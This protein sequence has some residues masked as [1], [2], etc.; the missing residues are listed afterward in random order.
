MRKSA[1]KA[2]A[3]AIITNVPAIIETAPVTET[4][5][6][7]ETVTSDEIAGATVLDN[8]TG[9]TVQPEA[10]NDETATGETSNDESAPVAEPDQRVMRAERIAADRAA[11]RSLY[12]VFEANRLSVPVKP[13]SAFKLA[14]STCH[15]VS[16]N[17]SER[18]AAA[19]AVGLTAAGQPLADGSS[20]ARVFDLDGKS[21]ALENGVLR[22]A[23]SS[24]LITVSGASPEAEII[25]IAKNA[26]AKISGLLG[27]KIVAAI[28]ANAAQRAA[29]AAAEQA[30]A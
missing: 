16:R 27:S 15:P 3:A 8:E 17:P 2:A 10:G 29:A 5:P 24:G 18:Q 20:F 7:L 25:R 11:V 23:I 6:V 4:A 26:S 12:S 28:N 19:L 22:D 14:T 21:A 30:N 1:K 13:L 9:D